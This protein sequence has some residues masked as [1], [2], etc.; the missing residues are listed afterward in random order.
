[1]GQYKRFSINWGSNTQEELI[2]DEQRIYKQAKQKV[3]KK[4]GFYK[5]LSAFIA[6]GFFFVAMNV[7]TFFNGDADAPHLWFFY[8][9]LPWSIGLLIHYFS[10]F[11][12][13][14]SNAL[15]EK[16]EEEEL[17]KELARLRRMQQGRLGAPAEPEEGLDLK[18]LEKEKEA[19]TNWEEEDLV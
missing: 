15:S 5:H 19:R 13:P 14:G 9:M 1:M 3:E 7:A 17:A 2:M 10:I 12:L 8:P 16:W 18:E 11:G 4:K 6:V